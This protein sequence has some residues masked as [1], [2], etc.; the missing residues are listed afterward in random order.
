MHKV[1]EDS[2]PNLTCSA[3]AASL[4]PTSLVAAGCAYVGIHMFQHLSIQ[5]AV[6]ILGGASIG[7]VILVY[8]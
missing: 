2:Y 4:I 6:S 5:V 7:A 1:V 3:V 8:M